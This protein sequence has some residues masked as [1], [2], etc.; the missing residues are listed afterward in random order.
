MSRVLSHT[1]DNRSEQRMHGRYRGW[2]RRTRWYCRSWQERHL[3]IRIKFEDETGLVNVVYGDRKED[4][5]RDWD[6][7][8]EGTLTVEMLYAMRSSFRDTGGIEEEPDEAS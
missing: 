4:A 5:T 3:D 7:F 2:T 6:R 8:R 1:W